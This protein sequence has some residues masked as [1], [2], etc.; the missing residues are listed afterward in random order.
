MYEV[1]ADAPEVTKGV[2]SPGVR[3]A[4]SYESFNLGSGNREVQSSPR[5]VSVLNH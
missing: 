1:S 5:A 4:G 2:G 3:V